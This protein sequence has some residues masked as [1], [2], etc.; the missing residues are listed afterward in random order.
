MVLN[1][2]CR[3]GFLDIFTNTTTV[4]YV[5]LFSLTLGHAHVYIVDDYEGLGRR[6]DGIGGLS[7]GGA[8]SKLLVNYA[9]PQR[10]QILDYLFKPQFAA[11]LQILK[12]EIGGDSQS[13]DGTE[14]SHMHESWDENYQRGYEWWLM[15]EAKKRN[16][17]IKLYGLPWTFPGWLG[18]KT[19]NPYS[20]P[21][22]TAD[23]IVRWVLGARTHYGLSIDYIGIWNERA[24][25]TKY[26]KVLRASLDKNNLSN[27]TV[28]AADGSWG[29]SG[30]ILKDQTLAQAVGV[31]GVHYPGTVTTNASLQTNK[32]LWSSEDYSTFNDNV[33]AGCWGRILNQNYVN[34]FM[35]STISWNLIASYYNALP[36]GRDGLMTAVQPWSGHYVVE[37]PIWVTAHT[38]QFTKTGWHYLPHG[39]GV[40][41]LQGGGSYVSWLCPQRRHFTMVLETMSHNHSLCIRPALPG[42]NVQPQ[43]ATFSL[44]GSMRNIT[45]LHVWY[46]K[47]GFK[48]AETVLFKELNPIQVENGVFSIDLAVDTIHTLTTWTKG[49]KGSYPTPPPPAPFTLPYKDDFESYA[50]FNEAFNFA[51]QVGV[52]EVRRTNDRHHGNVN[53]QV[54]L[55]QPCDWCT[56]RIPINIGGNYKWTN[57]LQ[58]IDVFVPSVNGTDGVFLAQ[59][60]SRGGCSSD[61]AKGIFFF[62]FPDSRAF[63]LSTDPSIITIIIIVTLCP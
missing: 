27:V 24:Y 58:Q 52:W 11:S 36:F 38:S 23:Y 4:L 57:L 19:A 39:H 35:T 21:Y 16:P 47:L 29:I 37:S 28:V 14:S 3:G 59:H 12:V 20:N 54:I 15:R 8:T 61:K 7:G 55:H 17:D 41:A 1:R 56:N 50:E 33:G 63:V 9:E 62:I 13:T 26:I 49:Q 5:W 34:G 18:G 51:P 2:K 53:R 10:S 6:F 22:R 46:S 48:D 30:D 43:R 31:I 60:V 25:N 44:K 40:G 45:K 32:T 42:Y